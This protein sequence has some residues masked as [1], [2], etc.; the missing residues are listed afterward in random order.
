MKKILKS[1]AVGLALAAVL[2]L[3]NA[4]Q[5]RADIILSLTSVTPTGSD[6]TYTYSVLL[7]PG[8][9]LHAAGGGANSGVAPSNSYFTLYDVQGLVAGSEVYGGALGVPGNSAK[10]EQGLGIKPLTETPI[11][12]DDAG[13]LNI[14]TYWTGTDVAAAP[15]MG[16]DLGVFT[17]IS[18]NALGA[19][20]LAFTGASQKLEMFP[21]LVANNTGQVAGP[22]AGVTPPVPEPATLALLA[23]GLPA[24]GGFC[25][26]RRNK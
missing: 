10:S 19:S 8:S 21:A 16:V 7:T 17:F 5:A 11:P 22:G 23:L 13:I 1:M 15:P 2:L 9:V 14:T 26:R 24:I 20:M 18:H 3:M 25:Y 4:G 6:F 12:P